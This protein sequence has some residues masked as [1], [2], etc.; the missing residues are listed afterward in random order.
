MRKK[1]YHIG[2]IWA[3]PYSENLGVGALAYSILHILE[4]VS[5]KTGVVFKYFF[6]GNHGKRNDFIQIGNSKVKVKN[7]PYSISS[8]NLINWFKFFLKYPFGIF[9]LMKFN[10][11]VDM[12]EGD[13]FSD[14]YGIL[15]FK[16]INATKRNLNFFEKK[17][18]LLPQTIGPFN[19]IEAKQEAIKSIN[20]AHLV[21]TRDRQSYD[22]VK[23][24]L[25]NK[26]V[27]ELIDMAFFM[28]YHKNQQFL[29]TIRFGI[30]VSGLLWNGGYT[31]N[32]Q[33][34]L[35]SNYQNLIHT[36][37]RSFLNN[38]EVDIILI[39]HVITKEYDNI[40]ND[41][42][43]CNELNTKYPKTK[44]APVFSNP[45]EA[46]SFISGLDFF[47]G[48]R[49]HGC[50]AAFSTGV[51]VF[52][53]AYSRKFNGLFGDTLNYKYFGDLVN[54]ST[55]N[56]LN[57]LKSSFNKRDELKELIRIAQRDFVS[58]IEFKLIN[59]LSDAIIQPK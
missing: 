30:N 49:M 15:R 16:E 51:P 14:I 27:F 26:A 35:K 5:K 29:N 21:T 2:I 52:P 1:I 17:I 36:I 18:I 45:I 6:V 9:N 22:Y 13:S 32:N 8:T 50:I 43:I 57:D 7:Y 38:S 53:L 55:D 4:K 11:V 33:F 59:L 41:L 42:K 56:I 54:S 37:I 12:G 34:H 20:K 39:S 25:P 24:L 44:L 58:Q 48:S 46:K 23:Q 40:E 47:T 3:N 28:P 19:L 31:K 10:V